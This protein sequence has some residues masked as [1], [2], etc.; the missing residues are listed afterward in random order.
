MQPRED[1]HG[2]ALGRQAPCTF[3]GQRF[4]RHPEVTLTFGVRG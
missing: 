4:S 3:D 2:A 1:R